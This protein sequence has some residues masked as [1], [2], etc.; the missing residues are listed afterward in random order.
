MPETKFLGDRPLK[1]VALAWPIEFDGK[2]YRE[3]ALARLT[4]R[5]VSDFARKLAEAKADEA[6]TFPI[7][8]DPDGGPLPEGLLGALDDDDR[9][10]LDEAARDFLPRRF[11]GAE[12]SASAPAAGEPT[13]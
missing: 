13:A 6:V 3:I 10:A 9:L 11:R 1:R 12:T 4:A 5:E 8:R 2:P 7:F